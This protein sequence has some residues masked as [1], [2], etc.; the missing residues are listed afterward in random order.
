MERERG[1]GLSLLEG[2]AQ[3]IA[4]YELVPNLQEDPFITGYHV[5]QRV[6]QWREWNGTKRWGIPDICNTQNPWP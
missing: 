4:I 2:D 3:N 6:G 5:P 1:S